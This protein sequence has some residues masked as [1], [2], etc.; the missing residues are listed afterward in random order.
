MWV[1]EINFAGHQFTHRVH[2][3]RRPLLR[4]AARSM[5]WRPALLRNQHAA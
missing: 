2:D 3:R 5:G 1:I 4:F